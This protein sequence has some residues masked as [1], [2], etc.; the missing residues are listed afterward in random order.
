MHTI[1][2]TTGIPI[3]GD[4]EHVDNENPEI[5]FLLKHV[6]GAGNEHEALGEQLEE[7]LDELRDLYVHLLAELRVAVRSLLDDG[8]VEL[9]RRWEEQLEPAAGA[10]PAEADELS[11][12]AYVGKRAREDQRGETQGSALGTVP[13]VELAHNWGD[14]RLAHLRLRLALGL[15]HLRQVACG[16]HVVCD[17]THF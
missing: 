5:G 15:Q 2:Y 12:E 10:R 9:F 3:A 11:N 6:E 7:L 14:R 16:V 4:K 8:L 17:R 1:L 13:D